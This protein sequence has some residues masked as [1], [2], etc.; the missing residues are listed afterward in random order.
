[1]LKRQKIKIVALCVEKFY[2]LN[3]KPENFPT[4]YY[5]R[6]LIAKYF[7]LRGQKN[8]ICLVIR[9]EMVTLEARGPEGKGR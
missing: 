8:H 3:R 7:F 5:D 6:K 4:N 1:M 9:L 2:K